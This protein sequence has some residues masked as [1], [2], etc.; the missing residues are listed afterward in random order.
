MAFVLIRNIFLDES[1]SLIPAIV[2]K[3]TGVLDTGRSCAYILLRMKFR[4]F[5]LDGDD[6]EVSDAPSGVGPRGKNYFARS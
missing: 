3:F 5:A 1:H 6:K 4:Q 2:P